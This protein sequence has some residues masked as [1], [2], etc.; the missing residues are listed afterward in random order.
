MAT[1]SGP[2]RSGWS[3]EAILKHSSNVKTIRKRGVRKKVRWGILGV[4]KI[5]MEKVIPAMQ[6]GERCEVTAIASRSLA[7][8]RSA[9]RS[10]GIPK[11]YGSYEELL[12]DPEIDAVYNPLPNHLHVPWS[13]QA[14][15]AGKHVLCEKPL[16]L[17]AAEA[18]KL[19]RARDRAG[20]LI[21]EAVMVK[22]HPQ[23]LAARELF[24][25]GGLGK[26]RAVLGFFS[27]F[28]RDPKNV[29]NVLEFGGG[30]L[31][32]IGFYPITTSRFFFGEEPKRVVSLI[33]RDPDFKVDRLASVILDFPSGQSVFTCGTQIVPYQ[34]MQF[35]GTRGR[36][37]IEVPFNAPRDRPCRVFID[38]GSDLHGKSVET[39]EISTCDQY[40]IQGDLFSRAILEGKGAPVPLEDAVANL[41]TIDAVFRS[42]KSGR[43][44]KP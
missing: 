22:T 1:L 32:D 15:R 6:G 12:A 35:F 3:Q 21:G 40:R 4:A 43:W 37:E 29:R 5:A 42:A 33:E 10:L 30:G 28:N 8:A 36:V 18:R 38:D 19:L 41:R 16:A 26:P 2:P 20:V 7:R 24:R 23:W 11:A 34:R 44:E 17:D 39:L 27:F 9:A 14:A 31:L 13:V 25:S